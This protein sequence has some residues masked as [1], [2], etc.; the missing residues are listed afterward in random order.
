LTYQWET[1]NQ[2][3]AYAS[4]Q[5][6]FDGLQGLEESKKDHRICMDPRAQCG[7]KV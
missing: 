2:Y 5:T 7:K 1:D 4:I 3:S 6:A